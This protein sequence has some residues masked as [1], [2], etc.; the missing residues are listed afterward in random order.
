MN[1]NIFSF[2]VFGFPRRE[3]YLLAVKRVLKHILQSSVRCNAKENLNDDPPMTSDIVI[4]FFGSSISAS[5][6]NFPVPFYLIHFQTPPPPQSS[7]SD[8][9]FRLG[10]GKGEG[11]EEFWNLTQDCM[12]KVSKQQD[13]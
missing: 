4:C 2:C 12:L 1:L 5:C 13:H 8:Y 9:P 7:N 10:R 6:N 3:C 11:G